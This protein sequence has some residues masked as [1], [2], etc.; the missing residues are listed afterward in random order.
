MVEVINY[1]K[2]TKARKRYEDS[3]KWFIMDGIDN[4]RKEHF[5]QEEMYIVNKA[6]SEN[7]MIEKGEIHESGVYKYDG[8]IY[9]FRNKIGIAAICQKYDL[10]PED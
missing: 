9:T 7:W 5:T 4:L 3:C 10:Y 8:D 2:L 1:S 6:I